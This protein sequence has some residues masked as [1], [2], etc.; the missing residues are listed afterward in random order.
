MYYKNN[1]HIT[2][3]PPYIKNLFKMKG[4]SKNKFSITVLTLT[5]HDVSIKLCLCH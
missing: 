5:G 1:V 4:Q 3:N 2:I